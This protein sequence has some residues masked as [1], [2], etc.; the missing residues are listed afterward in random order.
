MQVD[1]RSGEIGNCGGEDGAEV[2][3]RVE[4]GD[5]IDEGAKERGKHLEHYALGYFGLGSG[6]CEIDQQ[7]ATSLE[8]G[9]LAHLLLPSG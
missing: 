9:G 7:R 5:Q 1:F 3:D 2:I 8:E 6:H 4:E